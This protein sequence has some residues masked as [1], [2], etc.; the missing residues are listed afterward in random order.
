MDLLHVILAFNL[1][2]SITALVSFYAMQHRYDPTPNGR[3]RTTI[4]FA[5]MSGAALGLILM[6]GIVTL[7]I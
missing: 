1:V 5:G 6:S 3:P 7:F 4:N 2:T